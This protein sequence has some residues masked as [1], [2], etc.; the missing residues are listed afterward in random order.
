VVAAWARIL[1]NAPGTRLL[2]ANAALA[3]DEVCDYVRAR[4]ADHGTGSGQLELVGTMPHRDR[5]Q[6]Y[7]KLD[8]AL[9]PVPLGDGTTTV[10]ALWQG[11]PVLTFA[12]GRWASRIGASLLGSAGLSEWLA[13]DQADYVARAVAI[14]ADPAAPRRLR[15]LR[16]WMRRRL[17][18]SG[19]TP[20]S[21]SKAYEALYAAEG[22]SYLTVAV[23]CTGGQHRS[24]YMADKL[25]AELSR[26]YPQVLTRHTGLAI[27]E[28]GGVRQTWKEYC[29]A[30]IPATLIALTICNVLLIVRYAL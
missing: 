18:A 26:H 5:L 7:E 17:A 27:E 19:A 21:H 15:A 3:A 28:K 1:N 25:A 29:K 12:G 14:A 2:L 10:E 16:T 23:G 24:V 13:R 22:K 11:V 20:E 9:D 6:L 8:V 4:F 30:A